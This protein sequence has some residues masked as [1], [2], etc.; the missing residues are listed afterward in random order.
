M[1]LEALSEEGFEVDIRRESPAFVRL[2]VLGLDSE[3][4]VDLAADARLFLLQPGVVS[5]VLTAE[6]LLSLIHI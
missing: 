3:T 1:L 4:E 5:L 2:S 6:E